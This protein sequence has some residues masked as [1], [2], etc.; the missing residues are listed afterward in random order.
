[1]AHSTL[2]RGDYQYLRA[3]QTLFPARLLKRG[4][5]AR[6][7]A[8]RRRR[9]PLWLLLGQLITWF[10]HAGDALPGLLRWGRSAD[11]DDAPSDPAIDRARGRLG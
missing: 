3:F 5:A 10:W 9:L 8:T 6:R 2:G 11:A 4:V 7:R 1:M